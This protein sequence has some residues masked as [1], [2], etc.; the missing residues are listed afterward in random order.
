M[1][2][3][4]P[5]VGTN[6]HYDPEAFDNEDIPP[7]ADM[8][9]EPP[10]TGP[11]L[12]L[13]GQYDIS[14]PPT[15]VAAGDDEAA[16]AYL[17]AGDNVGAVPSLERVPHQLPPIAQRY[18]DAIGG[19]GVQVCATVTLR[20]DGVITLGPTTE[21]S[22]AGRHYVP[23][24]PGGIAQEY[25]DAISQTN[26]AGGETQSPNGLAADTQDMV[27][28][29]WEIRALSNPTQRIY[30]EELDVEA[31]N[32]S[33]SMAYHGYEHLD[34]ELLENNP[35]DV[36][37]QMNPNFPPPPYWGMDKIVEGYKF[38]AQND[39]YT[40]CRLSTT[41][42]IGRPP[43]RYKE[44]ISERKHLSRATNA[45]WHNYKKIFTT[46][47]SMAK[48]LNSLNEQFF[49]VKD[50]IAAVFRI[51]ESDRLS[52][53]RISEEYACPLPPN[54]IPTQPQHSSGSN[55]AGT[56]N[57]DGSH[58]TG[59]PAPHANNNIAS[60]NSPVVQ[61]PTDSFATNTSTFLPP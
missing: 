54:F 11:T 40:F 50:W 14:P 48:H 9:D 10:A 57:D 60:A 4:L 33:S 1:S 28:R 18:L 43:E 12:V 42:A 24:V 44:E 15:H 38:Q 53:Q 7:A 8:V 58:V 27:L 13:T 49:S 59:T 55:A 17:E 51:V 22:P 39:A 3:P 34:D 56:S 26:V 23:R 20:R 35:I 6:V 25:I 16:R 47:D 5:R 46:Y 29:D 61:P 52:E 2:S 31:V 37:Y 30:E 21:Q 45:A 36:M 32:M 19:N 41:V